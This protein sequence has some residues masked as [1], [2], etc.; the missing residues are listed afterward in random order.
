MTLLNQG[1]DQELPIS[2]DKGEEPIKG[3]GRDANGRPA[4]DHRGDQ[5]KGADRDGDKRDA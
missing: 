1:Q 4:D 5:E 3:V 2:C